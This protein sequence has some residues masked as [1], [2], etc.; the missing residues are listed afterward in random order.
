MGCAHIW[1]W[2]SR[3][4]LFVLTMLAWASVGLH[5]AER[6]KIGL[7]LSGGGARG[8]AHIGVLKVL[9]ELRIPID[10]IAGTS[11][12]SIV[13]GLYAMGLTPAEIEQIVDQID[14]IGIFNDQAERDSQRMRRKLE[15]RNT[16]IQT[17]PGVQEDKRRINLAP[18]LI[19]GQKLDLALRRYTLPAS[20]IQDF[21][22]LPIPYRAVATDVVTG[23]PVILGR[24]SL[25]KAMR[26]SMAVPAVFAPVEIGDRLLVDGGLAMNLPI[27]AVRAMG[28]EIV[29]AVDVSGPRRERE[30][31]GDLLSMLDQI[32]SLVTWRNTQDEIKGLTA[33]DILITPPLGSE[34]LANEFTKMKQAIALGER[35]AQAA[36]PQLARLGRPG[37]PAV[38]ARTQHPALSGPP[39]PIIRAIRIDTRSRLSERLI[40]ERIQIKLGEPLD[41]EALE[42]QIAQIH[43]LDNFESVRYSL[44]DQTDTEATLVIIAREKSWGT[45]SLQAGLEFSSTT[46]GDSRFNIGLAYTRL[47][48][49]ALNG[50]WRIQAQLG[51]EPALY[52]SLYQPLDPLE[53]WY[54]G[55]SGGYL[56]ENLVLFE[57]SAHN[58]PIAEYQL[59]RSGGELELGRNLGNWGRLGLRYGRFWGQAEQRIGDTPYPDYDF[60]LGELTLRLTLDTLDNLSFPRRGWL[61]ETRLLG[62][63]TGLGASDDYDQFGLELLHARQLGPDSLLV[64]FSLAGDL[65][66][67]LPPQAYQRLGGFLNL[68]GFNQNELSG[69]NRG[70]VR[71]IYLH[72]LKTPLLKTYTG[73][74]LEAGN[75]WAERSAIGWDS[76]RLAGSLFL[77]ADTPIGPLYLG[78]GHADGGHG[79]LYLLL[80]RP[81]GGLH[82][83]I[84][85]TY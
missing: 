83:G 82:E 2:R 57:P 49:N 30:K 15:D 76:L 31:I 36:R 1:V 81:W 52:T 23:E 73:A 71:A 27:S 70:L 9:E 14:W 40:R 69:S 37:L 51:E 8:A 28:A 39:R 26:A 35:A 48:L 16:L 67:I 68:S 58:R 33:R 38:A 42:R 60:D 3:V 84:G 66:G 10:Y 59:V 13:G 50:D 72:D 32:A 45:S 21:D 79:A 74:S 46:S 11:M 20:R 54:L 25:A 61:A 62:S 56:N 12:G 75:V 43:D 18:A 5:A 65:G 6:P 78:Y 7:A 22:Q 63:R 44:A 29:I 41:L 24:G 19:Q 85:T 47:P 80:G 4:R 64:G 77:G 53:R 17:R 55:V 34:V